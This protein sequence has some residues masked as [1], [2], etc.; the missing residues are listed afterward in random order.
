[1]FASAP[2]QQLTGRVIDGILECNLCLGLECAPVTLVTELGAFDR[3]L[4]HVLRQEG[5][6]IKDDQ[7]GDPVIKVGG[8]EAM[9]SH[10]IIQAGFLVA[11]AFRL[12]VRIAEAR[13]I[14]IIECGRLERRARARSKPEARG[15]AVG[16]ANDSGGVVP[17]L[18]VVILTRIRLPSMITVLPR[19]SPEYRFD[20]TEIGR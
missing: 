11:R 5:C 15:Y 6:S 3:G 2:L 4:A 12:Q 19:I 17:E 20:R 16:I 7:I 18:T 10:L 9:I 8:S 1:M 14:K 13:K